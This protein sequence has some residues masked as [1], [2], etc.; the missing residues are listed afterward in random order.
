MFFLAYKS[1]IIETDYHLFDVINKLKFYVKAPESYT[2]RSHNHIVYQGFVSEN[3]FKL[4]RIARNRNLL[5]V[6]IRC[7]FKELANGTKINVTVSLHPLIVIKLIFN[8][9][10]WI[11]ALIFVTFEVNPLNKGLF[12]TVL[13]FPLSL[14]LIFMTIF[15]LEVNRGI[16]ELKNIL[17]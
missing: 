17:E 7:K 5:F 14:L 1:F 2:Y 13:I 9:L 3:R 15:R 8:L 12:L 6:Q 4:V 16:Y 11:R 10:F